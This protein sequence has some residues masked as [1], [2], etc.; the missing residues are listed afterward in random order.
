MYNITIHNG[1]QHII[2]NI[3]ILMKDIPGNVCRNDLDND[4]KSRLRGI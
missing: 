4:N 3:V 2:I 1:R